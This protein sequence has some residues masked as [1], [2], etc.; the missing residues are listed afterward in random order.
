MLALR[1]GRP[2]HP[3]CVAA[4]MAAITRFAN[5]RLVAG[6]PAPDDHQVVLRRNQDRVAAGAA[7][8]VHA[9]VGRPG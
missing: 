7:R 1:A 5:S 4:G 2:H 9:S 8:A 6:V 3:Y